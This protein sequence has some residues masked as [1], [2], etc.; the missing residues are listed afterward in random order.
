MSYDTDAFRLFHVVFGKPMFSA[1]IQKDDKRWKWPVTLGVLCITLC[2]SVL[3]AAQTTSG[4]CPANM[5]PF[6]RVR[7]EY[8]TQ[9]AWTRLEIENPESV[10]TA[11]I[12][13]VKGA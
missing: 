13:A 11:R 2:N 12:M 4:G 8:A 6:Y 5:V 10:L 9:A 3:W 1:I 7:I